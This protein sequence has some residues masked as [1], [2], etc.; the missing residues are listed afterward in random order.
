MGVGLTVYYGYPAITKNL[1][2][3]KI[4]QLNKQNKKSQLLI[5]QLKQN[6]S[7]TSKELIMLTAKLDMVV[8]LDAE[9]Q[10]ML[11][12][13]PNDIT[14]NYW[15]E[16]INK[17]LKLKRKYPKYFIK[18]ENDIESSGALTAKIVRQVVAI[19]KEFILAKSKYGQDSRDFRMVDGYKS[20]WGFKQRIITPKEG[21]FLVLFYTEGSASFLELAIFDLHSNNPVNLFES[22]EIWFKH[23][24]TFQNNTI[25]LTK[26]TVSSDK[27]KLVY[28]EGKFAHKR[29]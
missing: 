19:A 18:I 20:W 6:L 10:I 9:D 7:A 12:S 23:E 17:Y 29:L 15:K 14:N 25:Y 2:E 5:S 13:I 27:Y 8:N 22:G 3:S 26:S 21:D 16:A 11:E 24:P 4:E 28:T 1:F